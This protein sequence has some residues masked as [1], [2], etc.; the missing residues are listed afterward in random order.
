MNAKIARYAVLGGCAYALLYLGVSFGRH[1]GPIEM[2][3][4]LLAFG[5]VA[6]RHA[7]GPGSAILAGAWMSVFALLSLVVGAWPLGEKVFMASYLAAATLVA[8]AGWRLRTLQAG[9]P[10]EDQ[11]QASND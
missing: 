2:M 6:A 10:A 9:A 8:F 3:L 5:T 7:R 1:G 11:A 4:A